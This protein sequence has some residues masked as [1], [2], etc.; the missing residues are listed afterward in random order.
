MWIVFLERIKRQL[1]LAGEQI[2]DD[3]VNAMI[4]SK[5]TQVFYR[6][7]NQ[8]FNGSQH[9]AVSKDSKLEKAY[10]LSK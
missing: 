9:K 8:P 5:S 1:D 7:R 2:T 3:E 4:D 6:Y 10:I